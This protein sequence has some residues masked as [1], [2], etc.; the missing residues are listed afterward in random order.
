MISDKYEIFGKGIRVI[1][2]RELKYPN[3][4]LIVPEKTEL[5]V[6]FTKN[7]PSRMV[8][9]YNG[10]TCAV[11]TVRAK[12]TFAGGNFSAMPSMNRLEKMSND[13][14]V[15]TATGKRVEPDGFAEDGSASWLLV[16]G[17]I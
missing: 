5:I 4:N 2:K 10:Q 11:K 3:K 14:I 12:E 6:F 1:T 8:F 13:G 7:D 15:T 9:E 16:L 17:V